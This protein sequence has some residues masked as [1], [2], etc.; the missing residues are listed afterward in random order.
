MAIYRPIR[1]LGITSATDLGAINDVDPPPMDS[2][3]SALGLKET[4]PEAGHDFGF[5]RKMDGPTI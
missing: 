3:V 4:P 5:L 2:A 1:D